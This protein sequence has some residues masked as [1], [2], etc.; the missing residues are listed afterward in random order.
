MHE[1]SPDALQGQTRSKQLTIASLIT[2][3]SRPDRVQNLLNTHT[4]ESHDI[5]LKR[6]QNTLGTYLEQ[7][8]NVQQ[9]NYTE[10]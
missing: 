5:I 9:K 2:C 7:R 8:E 1:R 6:Y 10:N 4:P 3:A